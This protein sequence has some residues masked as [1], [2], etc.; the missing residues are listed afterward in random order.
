MEEDK[1]VTSIIRSFDET[2][3]IINGI[4]AENCEF[5]NTALAGWATVILDSE[6]LN[7][8]DLVPSEEERKKGLLYFIAVLQNKIMD[9]FYSGEE[10][11]KT[12]QEVY[13]SEYVKDEDGMIIGTKMSFLRG[14]NVAQ[15]SEKS[16]AAYV[17]TE[18]LYREGKISRKP[19]LVLSQL[20]SEKEKAGP[21]AFIVFDSQKDEFPTKHILYDPENPT[22][23]KKG[24]GSKMCYAG[25]YALTDEEYDDILTGVKCSPK[26]LYG[27]A[28]E[29]IEMDEEPRIYGSK[30]KVEEKTN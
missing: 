5:E 1:K 4:I 6:F 22:R 23:L 8:T 27:W 30:T 29:G 20:G 18:K 13:G 9:Y 10:T 12:R 15:C 2:P 14:K 7:C 24:D 19:I 16:L 17:V 28:Y 26:S 11:M 21:H 3:T 25:L